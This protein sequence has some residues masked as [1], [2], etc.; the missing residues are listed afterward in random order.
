MNDL[1]P[2]WF[3]G[4]HTSA[5]KDLYLLEYFCK[6]LRELREMRPD[7]LQI[8]RKEF[9]RARVEAQFVGM[10]FEAYVAASFVRKHIRFVKSES[11]DFL[12]DDFPCSIE[13][14]TARVEQGSGQDLTYKVTSAIRRKAES[15]SHR[16]DCLLFIDIT[17]LLHTSLEATSTALREET[18]LAIEDTIFVGAVLFAHMFNQDNGQLQ[19]IYFREDNRA[20]SAAQMAF[21]DLHYPISENRSYEFSFPRGG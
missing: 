20:P 12:L 6:H 1:V 14:T 16:N 10:R 8:F 21:L 13:C 15:A 7:V 9:R 18:R 4:D 11:P 2:N 3:L 19:T 5:T 17:N